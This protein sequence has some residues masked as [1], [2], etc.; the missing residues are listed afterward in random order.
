MLPFKYV[1]EDRESINVGKN[2]PEIAVL[3]RLN[4]VDVERDDFEYFLLNCS[5]VHEGT[6]VHQVEAIIV[7]DHI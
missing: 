5:H 2:V 6:V 3:H 4:S 1:F 7:S